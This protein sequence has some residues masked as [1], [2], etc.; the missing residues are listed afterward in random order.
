M[1]LHVHL[2]ATVVSPPLLQM[3]STCTVAEVAAP[4]NGISRCVI[5]LLELSKQGLMLSSNVCQSHSALC[6]LLIRLVR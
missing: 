2:E 4:I 5:L 3:L 1:M 6:M